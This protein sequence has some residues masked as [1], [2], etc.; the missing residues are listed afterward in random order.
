[1]SGPCHPQWVTSAV[2]AW[3][4]AAAITE[5]RVFA[6][7]RK[8]ADLGPTGCRPTCCGMLSDALRVA[9]GAR[10]HREAWH[11]RPS[12][13][14]ARGDVTWR[15]ANSSRSSSSRPRLYSDDGA[16]GATIEIFH[17]V[18]RDAGYRSGHNSRTHRRA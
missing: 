6:R 4:M 9:A 7:S 12:S 1:M 2:D 11:R 10:R 5:G 17:E 16:I 3:T 13:A 14:R 8:P 18:I 15:A